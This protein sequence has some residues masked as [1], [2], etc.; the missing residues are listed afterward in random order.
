MEDAFMFSLICHLFS[1]YQGDRY[2][3]RLKIPSQGN[4]FALYEN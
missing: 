1:A 2:K 4:R 3:W